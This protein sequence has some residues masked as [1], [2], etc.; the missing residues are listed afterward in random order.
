M[1]RPCVRRQ[2]KCY[3]NDLIPDHN[4]EF[5]GKRRKKNRASQRTRSPAGTAFVLTNGGDDVSRRI[6]DRILRV[7][8]RRSCDRRIRIRRIHDRNRS[9]SYRD[10][11]KMKSPIPQNSS[12]GSSQPSNPNSN[13]GRSGIDTPRKMVQRYNRRTRYCRNR[14]RRHSNGRHLRSPPQKTSRWL[15]TP[16]STITC[17]S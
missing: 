8:I 14:I 12:G 9:N 5:P 13:S 17:A 10:R 2:L 6:R 15:Q 16:Q 4:D 7:R 11:W 3:R 1:I